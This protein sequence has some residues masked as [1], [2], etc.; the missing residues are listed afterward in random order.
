MAELVADRAWCNNEVAY[1]YWKT[2]GKSTGASASQSPAFILTAMDRR[3]AAD[4]S[5][6]IVSSLMGLNR[7]VSQGI[8]YTQYMIVGLATV[9]TFS[10]SFHFG[11]R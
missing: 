3:R 7:R 9:A 2:D 10:L 1:L 4:R 8:K 6:A 5:A 11:I